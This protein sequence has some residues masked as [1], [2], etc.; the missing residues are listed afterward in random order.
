MKT[1][2]WAIL[3]TMIGALALQLTG[4]EHWGEA[5]SPKFVAGALASI[6]ATLAAM[7]HDKPHN[8]SGNPLGTVSSIRSRDRR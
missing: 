5:T 3:A 1:S 2:H 6:A 8:N 4:I 7:F